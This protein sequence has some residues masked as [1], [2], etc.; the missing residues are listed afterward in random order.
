MRTHTPDDFN[1]MQEATAD[2]TYA[3][4]ER[5]S[6]LCNLYSSS[7]AAQFTGD[8]A[9]MHFHFRASR[10]VGRVIAN[11]CWRAPTLPFS[12]PF[13]LPFT[14]QPV[15]KWLRIEAWDLA[16][17]PEFQ[18]WMTV[19][20]PG[21]TLD[22]TRGASSFADRDF[23]AR[24]LTDLVQQMRN[25]APQWAQTPQP[26]VLEIRG[27]ESEMERYWSSSD[28][29][30]PLIAYSAALRHTMPRGVTP[31]LFG[32]MAEPPPWPQYAD[33]DLAFYIPDSVIDSAPELLRFIESMPK[34]A[35]LIY[36]VDPIHHHDPYILLE[37][38]CSHYSPAFLPLQTFRLATTFSDNPLVL[39]VIPLVESRLF[40]LEAMVQAYRELRRLSGR[41]F[42]FLDRYTA[43]SFAS[44]MLLLPALLCGCL[45]RPVD[46]RSSFEIFKA[47]MNAESVET[48]E[49]LERFR[50][51]WQ[52]TI[53]PPAQMLSIVGN[54][55]GLLSRA[56]NR[57]P[58]LITH[59]RLWP[60]ARRLDRLFDAI[61]SRLERQA[62]EGR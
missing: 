30:R 48:I 6:D 55:S 5:I 45:G 4:Q 42:S 28:R 50:R 19:R 33:V 15:N 23:M 14:N 21:V 43:K 58:C 53:F 47:E 7:F 34:L 31:L 51:E 1:G 29:T 25:H 8:P 20:Q 35:S 26:K 32:S 39:K 37:S 56:I 61:L 13:T 22:L 2:I 49:M 38:N 10:F 24:Y 60:I 62:R 18:T 46:K 9:S 40:S 41:N 12:L 59:R 54:K 16:R 27:R 36:E 11:M 52:W 57:S 17:D 44:L 3:V